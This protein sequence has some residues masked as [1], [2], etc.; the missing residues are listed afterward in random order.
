MAVER[1]GNVI[2]FDGHE[3]DGKVSSIE[4]MRFDCLL[5]LSNDE[6]RSHLFRFT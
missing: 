5:S 4:W 1:C 3:N 2:Q 6:S